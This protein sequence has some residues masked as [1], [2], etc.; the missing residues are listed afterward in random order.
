[1]RMKQQ[2]D[3]STIDELDYFGSAASAR[4]AAIHLKARIARRPGRWRHR[5]QNRHLR[6]EQDLYLLDEAA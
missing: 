1:M 4:A 3:Y 2:A 5:M 6:G